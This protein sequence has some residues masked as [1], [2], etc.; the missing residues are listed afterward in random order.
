MS[1]LP[2]QYKVKAAGKAVGNLTTSAEQLPNIEV[3]PPKQFN[4]PGDK[5]SPE[6]LLIA[7]VSNCLIL[8]FRA[9]ARASKLEWISIECESVGELNKVEHKVQFTHVISKVKLLIPANEN[10]E[11][12]EKLLMK[13]E[14]SCLVNNSLSCETHIE[15]EIIRANE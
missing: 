7:A 10:S 4:G 15:C 3:A 2:H 8:S 6:D 13:A 9:I 12:A 1:D 14:G 5:W 11:K